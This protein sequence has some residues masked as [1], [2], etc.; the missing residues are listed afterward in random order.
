MENLYPARPREES[1][2]RYYLTFTLLFLLTAGLCFVHFVIY[3][4][5]LIWQDDGYSQ[6]LA[7]LVYYARW[8]R[9]IARELFENH[10]LR[11]PA[12][13]FSM[14]YGSDI[15]TVLQFYVTGD[16]FAF[17]AAFV[18]DRFIPVYYEITVFV[19]MWCA[20]AAFSAYCLS[21]KDLRRDGILAGALVY[22]FCGYS[23]FC[24]ARHPD[25]L[26]PMIWLPLLLL[27]IDRVLEKKKPWLFLLSVFISAVSNFYFFYMLMLLAALYAL[28]QIFVPLPAGRWR[29]A[30]KDLVRLL[31]LVI[32]GTLLSCM[33]LW[34]EI[35]LLTGDQRAATKI[36]Y[37]VIYPPQY[38][39]SFLGAFVSYDE[40]A[41]TNWVRLG[42][43]SPALL[44]I[45]LLYYGKNGKT[46][47]SAQNLRRLRLRVAFALLTFF[48]M[49]PVMQHI[50]NGF[51]YPSGRWHFGY[52]LLI[53]FI[54]AFCWPQ[55]LQADRKRNRFLLTAAGAA[56]AACLILTWS[57]TG[58]AIFSMSLALLLA[59]ILY[60][61]ERRGR[62][63]NGKSAGPAAAGQSGQLPASEAGPG[64]SFTE[65][66]LPVLMTAAVILAAAGMALS[67]F[68]PLDLNY[69]AQFPDRQT[70]QA[71]LHP[72]E[73]EALAPYM[74]DS[75]FS[76]YSFMDNNRLRFEND[77]V[78]EDKFSTGYYWSLQ[79]S[80]ISTFQD[81]MLTEAKMSL[82]Y[83]DPDRRTILMN[84]AGV[85]W[86]VRIK[87][88]APA[89]VPYG[90]EKIAEEEVE[91]P[92]GLR[93][94]CI[95]ENKNAL[96]LGFTS[97]GLISEEDWQAM[98]PFQRQE[99]L[100][101]GVY[102]K[103]YENADPGAD[104]VQVKPCFT[105]ESLPVQMTCG[106]GVIRQGKS[107]LVTQP[108]AVV[109][110]RTQ[111]L[112]E[113]ETYLSLTGLTFEGQ[114]SSR[115]YMEPRVQS[116][117][118]QT[119]DKAGISHS[120]FFSLE[121]PEYSWYNGRRDFLVN[122]Y[123]SQAAMEE[124]TITF[125]C[126]GTYSYEDLQVLCQPM[127]ETADRLQAMKEEILQHVDL[128]LAGSATDCLTGDIDL[129]TDKVLILSVP[130]SEG[131]TAKVDGKEARL[132]QA[133]TMYMGLPLAA[134]SHQIELTYQTPG[135]REGWLMTLAGLFL[136]LL[137]ALY[138]RRKGRI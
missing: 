15:P 72:A 17:P 110:L 103:D 51:S 68:S 91:R 138:R 45:F 98:T 40:A 19:R 54:T 74:D 126:R 44:C 43:A 36:A 71:G 30:G 107:F 39:E 55:L 50:F 7:G 48:L 83:S 38:Y 133:D 121:T 25:F 134:G 46:D 18:A 76:R 82:S 57:R 60:I 13:S 56:L 94:Y 97:A 75:D 100:L 10:T 122:L 24:A 37:D 84:L 86:A 67:G 35:R 20:G 101:Q 3:N 112:E 120:R 130:W 124:I 87:G 31:F 2:G 6:H 69:V 131:W 42:Y 78:F 4:K 92:D 135:Q 66:S 89:A 123:Y 29:Q 114:G 77:A 93:T 53:G 113:A 14:G 127:G 90:F 95:Y 128:H 136:C 80:G 109:T 58:N 41:G 117:K 88:L 99:A 73:L 137:T 27:G 119:R 106:S 12:W 129:Q 52:S 28:F 9:Q 116:L 33:I 64:R 102:L 22:T 11:I 70:L 34:P 49:L 32:A 111:G 132:Y 61:R 8:L 85:R 5:S 63:D 79:N 21:K 26:N 125:P 104:L 1:R 118:L 59:L 62:E 16:P 96:P 81:Q 105:G 65:K 47:G 108:G 23:L 115:Y